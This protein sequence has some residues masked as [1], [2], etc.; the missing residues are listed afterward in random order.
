M[1]EDEEWHAPEVKT[2]SRDEGLPIQKDDEWQGQCRDGNRQ[3]SSLGFQAIQMQE[4]YSP[5]HHQLVL[6]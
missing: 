4:F 1:S 6:Y 2:T 5:S 3:Y